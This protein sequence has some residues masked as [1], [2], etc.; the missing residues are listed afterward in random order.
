MGRDMS[1][2]SP[3][4]PTTLN[5]TL[6]SLRPRVESLNQEAWTTAQTAWANYQRHI[7]N[8]DIGTVSLSR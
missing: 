8:M 2:M 1:D 7:R 4:S 6:S 3:S 5:T